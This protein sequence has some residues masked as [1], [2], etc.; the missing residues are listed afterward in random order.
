MLKTVGAF[1]VDEEPSGDPSGD[2]E[3]RLSSER[4][5]DTETSPPCGASVQ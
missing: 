2:P 4:S 3:E 5:G 1:W